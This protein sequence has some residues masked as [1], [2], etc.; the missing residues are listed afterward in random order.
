MKSIMKLF[1][2]LLAVMLCAGCAL[3]E[4]DEAVDNKFN[5]FIEDGEFIIQVDSQGDL[6]W[7]ADD[8][9]QDPSVVELAFTD[10]V[11]DTFVARY[12]P[13]GDGDVTVGVRHYMGV[14]CDEMMTWDL[15]VADGAVREVTGGSYTAS[16]Y[17]EMMDAALVGEWLEQ[18]T[19]FTSLSIEK[20][21]ALGWDVTIVSP[22]SHGAYIFKTSVLYDCEL[23]SLVYGKG[24]FWDIDGEYQEGMELGEA[25]EAGTTG[26]FSFAGDEEASA[27]EWHDDT[28]QED[29]VFERV[30]S[31]GDVAYEDPEGVMAFSFDPEYFAITDDATEDGI[32]NVVL[33]GTR[34][35]C[36]E[37]SIVFNQRKADEG[38]EAP[39][40][41]AFG[42]DLEEGAE[43]TQGD[44][45]GMRDV[46]MYNN[47]TDSTYVQVF[48]VPLYGENDAFV[49]MVNIS[50]TADK[51]EDEEAAMGRDD[52]ISAALDSFK[53]ANY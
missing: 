19:Q 36:G 49:G 12:A 39:K 53:L 8:M 35:D 25:R 17:D 47:A 28:M 38:E 45:N 6:A 23:N 33:T 21:P 34:Q 29:I 7:I 31:S 26:A 42:D 40:L 9:A 46:I 14:A 11:E 48:I 1:A 27:L 3:A 22:V 51:L 16:V 5:S 37:Y 52:A 24:K 4:N 44:W 15:H 10:T 30:G 13:V 32:H 18:D 50:V 20:N 41:G 2:V 43:A